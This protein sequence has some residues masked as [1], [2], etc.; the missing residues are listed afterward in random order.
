MAVSGIANLN[1]QWSIEY[2]SR[3][4]AFPGAISY[5]DKVYIAGGYTIASTGIMT[6]RVDIYNNTT[7]TWLIDSLSSNREM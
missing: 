5:E 1:A 3:A 4:R 6:N 7:D 2:L